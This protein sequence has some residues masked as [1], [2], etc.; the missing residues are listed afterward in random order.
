MSTYAHY[1]LPDQEKMKLSYILEGADTLDVS[2]APVCPPFD[3]AHGRRASYVQAP[4]CSS[5]REGRADLVRFRFQTSIRSRKTVRAPSA[6]P[7]EILSLSCRRALTV[8][9][10]IRA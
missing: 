3:G 6:S 10:Q 5:V 2:A 7:L 9:F 1:G 4:W 8:K